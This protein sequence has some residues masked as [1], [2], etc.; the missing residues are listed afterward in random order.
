MSKKVLLSNND[1]KITHYTEALKG[2]ISNPATNFLFIFY[3]YTNQ[4]HFNIR[5]LLLKEKGI[6]EAN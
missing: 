1:T 6:K 2:S 3:V 4:E 5:N